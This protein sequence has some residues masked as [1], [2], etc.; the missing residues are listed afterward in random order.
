[1]PETLPVE[2]R[3]KLQYGN[4]RVA[5]N[6]QYLFAKAFQKDRRMLAV[7]VVFFSAE[8]VAFSLTG[9]ALLH[10]GQWK[11]G[12]DVRLQGLAVTIALVFGV[13]GSTLV[14]N[15]VKWSEGDPKTAYALA[16]AG[17]TCAW[18][19]S[20]IS[21]GFSTS[22]FSAL[23][24]LSFFGLGLGTIPAIC[25]QISAAAR[26]DRQGGAQGFVNAVGD[27]AWV[28]GRCLYSFALSLLNNASANTKGQSV[29]Y[30]LFTSSMIWWF[31]CSILTL[32]T[33]FLFSTTTDDVNELASSGRRH[34]KSSCDSAVRL[35]FPANL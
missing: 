31:S 19:I 8:I 32:G 27:M 29:A 14:P 34:R 20:C 10:W 5:L 4:I 13:V 28:V 6:S 24:S 2:R 22:S 30:S 3:E 26:S 15:V 16:I 35:P 9:G 1:M 11:F 12:W 7:L 25:S 18:A 33:Y 21:L 23:A 17:F